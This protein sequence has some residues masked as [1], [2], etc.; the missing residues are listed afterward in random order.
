MTILQPQ[1]CAAMAVLWLIAAAFA[2]RL[3]PVR[4]WQALW[5]LIVAG[6]P[7]LGWLTLHWGPIAGLAVFLIGA[8]LLARRG[9]EPESGERGDGMA[10]GEGDVAR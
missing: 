10:D 9:Q 7:L 8:V 2:G 4:H 6:V 5:A 1:L 3:P